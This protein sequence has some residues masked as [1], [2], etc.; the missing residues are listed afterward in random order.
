MKDAK[1]LMI[2]NYVR[3]NGMILPIV[4]ICSPKPYNTKRFN[5]KWLIELLCDGLIYAPVDEVEPIPIT[6]DI[7]LKAGFNWNITGTAL[8]DSNEFLISKDEDGYYFG[9]WQSSNGDEYPIFV[10]TLD[11]LHTLQNAY[12]LKT[13]KELIINF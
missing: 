7:L 4:S 8:W 6:E 13:N 9:V 3:Y 10:M 1:D 5:E 2:E 12:R 11:Y